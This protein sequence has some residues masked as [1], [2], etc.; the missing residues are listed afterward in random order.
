[1]GFGLPDVAYD[2]GN[3]IGKVGVGVGVLPLGDVRGQVAP[4]GVGDA[5]IVA[6][7]ITHLRFPL[8]MVRGELVHEDDRI[9]GPGFFDVELD[10]L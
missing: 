10:A 5:T 9:P 6:R 4:G 1:M 8:P 2:C 7:E 3:V